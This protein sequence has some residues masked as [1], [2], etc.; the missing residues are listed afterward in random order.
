M[1]DA[2]ADG[3]EKEETEIAPDYVDGGELQTG[4]TV[5]GDTSVPDAAGFADGGAVADAEKNGAGGAEGASGGNDD[6]ITNGGASGGDAE[7]PV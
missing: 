2:V 7:T 4:E 5:Q 1:E 6:S 3:T